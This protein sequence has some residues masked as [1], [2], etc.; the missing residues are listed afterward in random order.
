MKTPCT[1]IRSL[2]DRYLDEGLEAEERLRLEEHLESCDACRGAI[3]LEE[4]IAQELGALPTPKCPD[5]VIRS[6]ESAIG[7]AEDG[8]TWR[9]RIRA[10]LTT[11][12]WVPV[13]V[14]ISLA[15]LALLILTRPTGR[16][17][18]P[19]SSEPNHEQIELAEKQARWAMSYVFQKINEKGLQK[20]ESFVSSDLPVKIRDHLQGAVPEIKGDHQ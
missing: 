5:R 3:R 12:R 11:P 19:P 20:T 4:E 9:D 16:P 13:P 1:E 10:V 2:I 7:Q 17:D 18:A 6:I 8:A 15:V 14:V